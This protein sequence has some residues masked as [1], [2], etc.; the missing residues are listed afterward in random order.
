M[1]KVSYLWADSTPVRGPLKFEQ[2][3]E[4]WRERQITERSRLFITELVN[5]KT[6]R[7]LFI[8]AEQIRESLD[9]GTEPNLDLIS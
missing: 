7:C 9:A 5:E 2:V 6:N 1:V 3:C 8:D 4:L